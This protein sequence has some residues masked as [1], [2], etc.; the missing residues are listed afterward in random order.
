MTNMLEAAPRETALESGGFVKGVAIGL[1]TQNKDPEG[2]CRVK[3]RYPW[4]DQPSESYWARLSM[5]MAGNDRGMVLIPEVGDEVLLAFE[6]EDLRFPFVIGS[7]WNGKDKPPRHNDDG[8]NDERI[9]RS[10]KGHYLLFDD[11]A[12]G[13][14]E[15]AH[16]KGRKVI[17]DDTGFSV[18]DEK[19]NAV[20]V[21]SNSGSMT[22]EAKGPLKIKAASITLE[23]TGTLEV[24]ASA[25]LTL[26]G[27]LVQIN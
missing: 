23:A 7:L 19:G 21:D 10:R 5:P 9:L 15:L 1:V 8:K 6:R 11:G 20:T 27:S 16:E 13:V 2:L 22:I 4:H 18:Q 26:R 17:L 12:K 3:V 14:V 24:K 25:T